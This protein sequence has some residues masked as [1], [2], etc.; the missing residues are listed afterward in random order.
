MHRESYAHNTI[1]VAVRYWNALINYC[2][3]QRLTAGPRIDKV[4]Q[5]LTR[6]RVITP[7]EEAAMLAATC[8]NASYPGKTARTL[9]GRTTKIC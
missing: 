1:A 9:R 7:D 8:H 2:V 6:F 3:S 5:K 4:Q